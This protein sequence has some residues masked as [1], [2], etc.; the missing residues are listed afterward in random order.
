MGKIL[1]GAIRGLKRMKKTS[2]IVPNC[3]KWVDS[4]VTNERKERNMKNPSVSKSVVCIVA[5]ALMCGCAGLGKG[6]SDEELIAG[7]VGTWKAGMIEQ[8]VDKVMAAFSED[9][10]NYEVP[11]KD[12]M[13]EF[14]EGVIDMGYLEDAEVILEDAET[15]IDENTA[16]VYPIDVSTA[17][18]SVTIELTLTKEEGGWLITGMEIEGM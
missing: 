1:D 6:P 12:S 4:M 14:F 13:R 17:A 15:E 2:M 18:G 5:V 7:T 11:D 10:S 8:D 16:T 3:L 9:F